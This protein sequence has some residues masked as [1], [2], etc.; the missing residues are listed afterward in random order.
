MAVSILLLGSGFTGLAAEAVEASGDAAPQS[1]AAIAR[2]AELA[3]REALPRPAAPRRDA[4]SPRI[5]ARTPD[6]RLRLAPCAQP[7]QARLPES[8]G[9]IGPRTVVTVHCPGPTRWSVLVP[10][11]VEAEVIVLVASRALPRGV[12]PGPTD[13]IQVTRMLQGFS[14][15]Y[16]NDL[17]EIEGFHLARPLAPGTPLERA[18]LAVDPVVR[19]G[20]S[21]T[22]VAMHG[23]L[24]IRAT[25]RALADAAP[26]APVRV[27]NVNSLKIVEGRADS[28]GRVRVDP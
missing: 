28:S 4:A 12:R 1:L 9:G 15:S 19:R 13:L 7:L 16:I 27:Q 10:V 17:S 8:R 14:N 5:E 18:M 3:V 23:G 21:V 11:T 25:G 20:E 6:P 24:E 26:G 22:L 2:R